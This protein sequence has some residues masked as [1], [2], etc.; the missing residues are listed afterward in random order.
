M[1]WFVNFYANSTAK[2]RHSFICS[3]C[4]KMVILES[5]IC[6]RY[7]KNGKK[8]CDLFENEWDINVKLNL[9]LTKSKQS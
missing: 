9:N 3:V 4:K 1:E 2:Y 8:I 7:A 5:Y 6:K